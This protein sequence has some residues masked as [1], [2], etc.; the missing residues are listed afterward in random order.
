M[1]ENFRLEESNEFFCEPISCLPTC[2]NL[3]SL[4]QMP[5]LQE[6]LGRKEE[7]CDTRKL[8]VKTIR[9]RNEMKLKPIL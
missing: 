6:L 7:K 2:R 8:H 4:I 9:F 5:A 1:W 3:K